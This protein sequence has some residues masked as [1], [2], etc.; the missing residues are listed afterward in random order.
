[1]PR[2]PQ[3]PPVDAY[4]LSK[5]RLVHKGDPLNSY[6]LSRP[7]PFMTQT[8]T[9]TTQTT[10]PPSTPPDTQG[11]SGG[12]S[13]VLETP[14]ESVLQLRYL[15]EAVSKYV[16]VLRSIKNGT[17]T[18]FKR[19][20]SISGI[21]AIIVALLG[22]FLVTCGIKFKG[23][24]LRIIFSFVIYS[25]L[26]AQRKYID[27]VAKGICDALDCIEIIK[28]LDIFGDK[29]RHVLG[30]LILTIVVLVIL[31]I[32]VFW[33]KVICSLF[34]L[35][36]VYTIY[37]ANVVTPGNET[38]LVTFGIVICITFIIMFLFWWIEDLI[39]SLIISF[40]GC[41]IICGLLCGFFDFPAKFD[42]FYQTIFVWDS[43]LETFKN[44]NFYFL[45]L[46]TIV[47]AI[48]QKRL[49]CK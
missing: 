16:E 20:L 28:N 31:G 1:M 9:E 8:T 19:L 33:I 18:F 46:P 27:T 29:D 2:T 13:T 12:Q 3:P 25:V 4:I 35:Y 7:T 38:S 30:Y 26:K 21:Y 22:I 15:S 41:S 36:I 40:L 32:V 6:I 42:E 49:Y 11:T 47:V 5:P 43:I 45:V 34:I 39:L 44:V 23:V 10:V 17:D 48:V 14:L 37:C 24:S